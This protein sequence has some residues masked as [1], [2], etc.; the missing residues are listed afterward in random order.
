[1]SPGDL[2]TR[3]T[4]V[5]SFRLEQSFQQVHQQSSPQHVGVHCLLASRRSHLS[6]TISQTQGRRA[7][8]AL[9]TL[10]MQKEIENLGNH[11]YKDDIDRAELLDGLSLLEVSKK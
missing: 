2:L 7:K 5:L 8:T 10:A 9:K 3:S 11:F 6:T 1:L 4:P